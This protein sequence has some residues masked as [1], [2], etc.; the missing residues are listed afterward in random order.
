MLSLVLVPTAT[1]TVV[2]NVFVSY[3][4][5]DLVRIDSI[6]WLLKKYVRGEAWREKAHAVVVALVQIV[7]KAHICEIALCIHP[8][9]PDLC[10]CSR[11]NPCSSLRSG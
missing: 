10:L 7:V 3:P 4:G 2:A 9:G 11:R 5:T 1:S 8:Q 6:W